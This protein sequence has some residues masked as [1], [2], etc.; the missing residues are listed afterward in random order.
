MCGT[1]D[2]KIHTLVRKCGG[3][4]IHTLATGCQFGF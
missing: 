3:G 2:H 4:G 1:S